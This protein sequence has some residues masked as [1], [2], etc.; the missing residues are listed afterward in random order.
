MSLSFQA[1]KY[2]AATSPGAGMLAASAMIHSILLNGRSRL[3]SSN[4]SLVEK[5]PAGRIHFCG[6]EMGHFRGGPARGTARTPGAGRAGGG[7]ARG[8][9]ERAAGAGNA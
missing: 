4:W 1:R 5:R 3:F 8:G 9:A 7:A 6:E 2:A